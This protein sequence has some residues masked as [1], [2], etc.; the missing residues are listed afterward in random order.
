M[1]NKIDDIKELNK[2]AIQ[3]RRDI[4]R[5][6]HASNSGHPGGSLG[7]TDFLVTLFFSIM[8]RKDNFNMDGKKVDHI[9]IFLGNNSIMHCSG[10]VKEDSLDSSMLR[11]QT[12]EISFAI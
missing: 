4:V 1:K 10:M 9:G 8:E 7:C 3:I 5:M 11:E 6:V 12:L 2:I